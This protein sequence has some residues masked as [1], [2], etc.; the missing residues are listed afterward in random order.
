MLCAFPISV[1]PPDFLSL[2]VSSDVWRDRFGA[3]QLVTGWSRA[4]YFQFDSIQHFQPANHVGPFLHGEK[5]TKGTM[6]DAA[7]LLDTCRKLP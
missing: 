2:S 4:V 5:L 1:C 6:P 3:V 7:Q